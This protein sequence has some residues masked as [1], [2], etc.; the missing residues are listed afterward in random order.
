MD[1]RV[2]HRD[3]AVKFLAE[4]V[5]RVFFA[6][7]FEGGGH[8]VHCSDWGD[9]RREAFGRVVKSRGINEWFEYRTW[10]AVREGVIELALT[11]VAAADERTNFAG[12]RVHRDQRHLDTRG[13]L[14]FFGPG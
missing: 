7:E 5:G 1:E 8:V 6:V 12:A 9:E 13:W 14:A 2:A 3:C 11:I 10:L 4:I